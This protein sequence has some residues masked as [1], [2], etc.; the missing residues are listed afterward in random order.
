MALI[1]V[2]QE[3]AKEIAL[4]VAGYA[5]WQ[6]CKFALVAN[7]ITGQGL[8]QKLMISLIGSGTGARIEDD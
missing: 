3:Q 4:G 5:G 7:N 8:G 1:A 2:T 6:V